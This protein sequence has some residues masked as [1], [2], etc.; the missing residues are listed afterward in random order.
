LKKLVELKYV[1]I[2][3]EADLAGEEA[4]ARGFDD[5]EEAQS[6]FA[7]KV[8]KNSME[9]KLDALLSL[10]KMLIVVS[11]FSSLVDIMYVFK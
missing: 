1:V 7:A 9:K 2:D 4:G 3:L 5:G 8:G 11:F 6:Q 10:L